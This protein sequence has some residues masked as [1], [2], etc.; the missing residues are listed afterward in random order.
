METGTIWIYNGTT[1]TDSLEPIPDGAIQASDATPL[2][3][4]GSGSAGTSNLYARGD[5]RHPED[6][7]KANVSDL[8]N[9]LLLAGNTQT[10]PM[11][12]NI[13]LG[14]LIILSFWFWKLLYWNPSTKCWTW[15]RGN[16]TGGVNL[17]SDLGDI[18]ANGQRIIVD[19]VNGSPVSIQSDS[20]KLTDGTQRLSLDSGSTV[21]NTGNF[22]VSSTG[23]YFNE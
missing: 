8:D 20:I 9:Y 12:G 21:L 14:S 6:T 22:A 2:V 19:G 17:T 7:N 3:D 10:T 23:K 5:H 18:K 15:N 16:G 1:W 4:S 13:W 11:T